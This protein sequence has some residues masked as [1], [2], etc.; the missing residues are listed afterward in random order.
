MRAKKVDF[1]S[2][3]PAN[4]SP[5]PKV[6]ISTPLFNYDNTIAVYTVL[7]I[8]LVM[9]RKLGLEAMLEYVERYLTTIERSNPKFR[10]AVSHALSLINVEKL[11]RDA[12][13]GGAK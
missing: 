3:N 6:K 9:K 2:V 10:L 8:L 12:T 13:H 11:Y 1:N 5:I 7:T 4:N